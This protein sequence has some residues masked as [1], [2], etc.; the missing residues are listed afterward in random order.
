MF[1]DKVSL[2]EK[3]FMYK[4]YHERN[5]DRREFLKTGIFFDLATIKNSEMNRIF[6]LI[7]IFIFAFSSCDYSSSF[8]SSIL[9]S[10]IADEVD[11]SYSEIALQK[12]S[13]ESIFI[14][15]KAS[16][17]VYFYSLTCAHCQAL[18]NKIIEYGLN[19]DDLFFCEASELVV[20][21]KNVD[22]TIGATS[23]EGMAIL[24]YPSLIA[25][26]CAVC[27]SNLAGNDSICVKLNL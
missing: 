25:I 7:S 20:I 10:S 19:H 27:V 5:A 26:D 9:S 18:K 14:N 21:K 4:L 24:G 6:G 2:L 22:S 23:I 13:W 17:F 15:V 11:H 12:I 3:I 1:C 16:Y 8:S